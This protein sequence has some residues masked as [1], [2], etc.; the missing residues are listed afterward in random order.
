MR[1]HE[2]VQSNEC[3]GWASVTARGKRAAPVVEAVTAAPDLRHGRWQDVLADVTCDAVIV[4]PPYGARTHN[5]DGKH[6]AGNRNDGHS[7]DGLAPSY[8]HWTATEIA[9]FLASWSHRCRGWIVALACSDLAPL[10]QD[11]FFAAGRYGFAPV[12]CVIRGMSVRLAG[13][14]PSSWTV[15]AIAGRPRTKAMATWGTLDGAYVGPS[16]PGAG[17]GRGKPPW[18]MEALVGDYT[19]PGDLVCDPCAGWGST[20]V[21]ARKLGRRGIGAEV[22]PDAYAIA[23]RR[24]RGDEARPRPE[25]PSLFETRSVQ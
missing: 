17:G 5:A 13:D 6:G 24:V 18:L 11:A 20:L 19:R 9:E 7:V 23:A 4:D 2:F 8:S 12:P 1:T 3:E 15:Y 21:A 14:G 25:Q 16:L 10:W 22:D